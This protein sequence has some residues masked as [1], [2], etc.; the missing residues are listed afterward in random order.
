MRATVLSG[1]FVKLAISLLDIPFAF[2]NS[3]RLSSHIFLSFLCDKFNVIN[4][5]LV[6]VKATSGH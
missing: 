5:N 6:T 4:A 2:L 1:S 3:L